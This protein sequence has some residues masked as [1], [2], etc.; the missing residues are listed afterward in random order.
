MTQTATWP[1]A[2]TGVGRV[3]QAFKRRFGKAQENYL[4]RSNPYLG[5]IKTDNTLGTE[6]Y[7]F[8]DAGYIGGAGAGDS[9][10]TSNRGFYYQPV[11]T[12][13]TLQV[14]ADIEHKARE[15]SKQD[16]DAFVN[17]QKH[18]INKLNKKYNNNLNKV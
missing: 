5:K 17:G 16:I 7:G 11:I 9:I 1:N 8:I 6:E 2:D 15:L 14:T 4:N 3:A 10:P 18:T 12:P 13:K